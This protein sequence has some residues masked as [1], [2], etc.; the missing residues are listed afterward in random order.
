MADFLMH[1]LDTVKTRIQGQPVSAA[2][3]SPKYLNMFQAYRT[4]LLEE[5][6]SRGLYSGITPAMSG[7]IPATTIYFGTYELTKRNLIANDVPDVAAHLTAGAI[8]D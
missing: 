8:G 4:I 1:S 7:S 6:I 5:G 2:G 3:A